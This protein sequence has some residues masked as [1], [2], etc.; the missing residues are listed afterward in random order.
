MAGIVIVGTS[1]CSHDSINQ[2]Q[3]LDFIYSCSRFC[4]RMVI[5]TPM[6]SRPNAREG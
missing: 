5:K 2:F 1:E 3:I 4:F 6:L